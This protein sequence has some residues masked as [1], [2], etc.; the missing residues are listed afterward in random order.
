MKNEIDDFAPVLGKDNIDWSFIAEGLIM[1]FGK[2]IL[3]FMA[4]YLYLNILA[5]FF[6]DH[7]PAMCALM[8]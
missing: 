3:F 6:T 4:G 5:Q 2:C 1:F 8:K 7:L